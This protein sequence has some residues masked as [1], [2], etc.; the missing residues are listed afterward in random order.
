MKVKPLQKHASDTYYGW[1]IVA[2]VFVLSGLAFGT[3]ASVSVF[4]KPLSE[5]FGWSRASTSIGYTVASFG[6]AIFGIIW[7]YIADKY[8]TRWFGLIGIIVMASSLFA[9][10]KQDTLLKFYAFYLMFGAFGGS[11]VGSPLYAN[12]GFWFQ[13]KPGLAIGIAAAGGAAGQGL[14]PYIAGVLIEAEGW[15][16]AYMYLS[17]IYLIIGIPVSLLLRESPVRLM[18][19]ANLI[20]NISQ[21]G[22]SDKE[23]V[24]WI[25][26]AVVF[27]CICMSV[28]IVHLVSLLTDNSFSL[29]FSTRVLMLLM[30]CGIFGR[31]LGGI[32]GDTFGA[33]QTYILMSFGQTLSVFWFPHLDSTIA[34]CLLAIFFGI[35][36]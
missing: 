36:Y 24:I 13:K 31:I 28:P 10:S 15:D 29:E 1:V 5:E 33:L 3:L 26:T 17:A 9:L 2:T 4:L 16:K 27:C 8:G 25:S 11:L 19:Q 32:L 35:T 20:F 21:K 34:I 12:V 22:L 7:G 30:F 18:P 14:L 6:S 23:V